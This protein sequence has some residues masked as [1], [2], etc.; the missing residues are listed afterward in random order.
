MI[1]KDSTVNP[2]FIMALGNDLESQAWHEHY[3]ILEDFWLM[4]GEKVY[5]RDAFSPHVD[6]GD[7]DR[8]IF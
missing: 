8:E 7:L 6:I 4:T 3:K 2:Y 5:I 1:L